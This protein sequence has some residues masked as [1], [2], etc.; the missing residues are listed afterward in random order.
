MKIIR[1]SGIAAAFVYFIFTL[2]AYLKYPGPFNPFNNW[3]SDLGN[4]FNNASGAVIYNTGCMIVSILLMI[5]YIGMFNWDAPKRKVKFPLIIAQISG[6]ISCVCLFMSAVFPLGSYT[7]IHSMFSLG[8]YYGIALFESF[9]A[10]A[11]FLNA[12]MKKWVAVFGYSA[13][14]VNLI[15]ICILDLFI[16]EWI[17]IILLII[18]VSILSSQTNLIKKFDHKTE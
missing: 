12:K 4:P 1:F 17:T 16:G 18:Y 3:L 13:S 2:A 9:S 11:F 5:F 15:T 7:E 8:I 14:I 6:I 10:V